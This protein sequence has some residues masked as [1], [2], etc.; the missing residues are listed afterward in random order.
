MRESA[1]IDIS[2]AEMAA[3]LVNYCLSRKIPMPSKSNKGVQVIGGDVTLIL[4]IQEFNLL[5]T[6][7]K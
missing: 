1:S 7:R 6:K 4:T 2:E 5:K 3:A